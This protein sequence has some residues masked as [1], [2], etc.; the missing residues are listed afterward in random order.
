MGVFVPYLLTGWDGSDPPLAL[1]VA[2]AALLAAGSA[3]LRTQ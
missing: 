1:Q 3:Y 2:G